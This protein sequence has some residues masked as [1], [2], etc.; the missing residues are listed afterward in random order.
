MRPN[1]LNRKTKCYYVLSLKFYNIDK[2]SKLI[3][4]LETIGLRSNIICHIFKSQ[5][6]WTAWPLVML[7][8]GSPRN[9]GLKPSY[10]T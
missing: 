1:V 7:E 5:A 4:Y 8:I 2:N 6:D 3:K 10:A 9:V